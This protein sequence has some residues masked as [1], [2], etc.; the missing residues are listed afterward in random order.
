[1]FTGIVEHMGTVSSIVPLDTSA[2]G[3][4]GF[5]ITISDAAP[6]LVDVNLGDSISVNGMEFSSTGC[7][8]IKGI[9]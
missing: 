8:W 7:L 3:G 5:S 6:V 9:L 4:G 1:M 2:T